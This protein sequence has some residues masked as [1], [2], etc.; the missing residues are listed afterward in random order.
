MFMPRAKTEVE[1]LIQQTFT[2]SSGYF[3]GLTYVFLS[4]LFVF[5]LYDTL[6]LCHYDLN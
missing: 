1:S 2:E 3:G 6:L 4:A 5:Y